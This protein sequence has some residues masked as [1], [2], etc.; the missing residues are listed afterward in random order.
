M[1]HL[2][3]SHRSVRGASIRL[4]ARRIAAVVAMS[5]AV[6]AGSVA[7]ANASGAGIDAI[8]EY[9]EL[10]NLHTDKC[11]DVTDASRSWNAVVHQ[12][13]CHNQSHQ[14]WRLEPIGPNY[15]LRNL[16]S[17]LCLASGFPY[18]SGDVVRQL[19]CTI[20]DSSGRGNVWTLVPD[21]GTYKI[22]HYYSGFCLDLNR[23]STADGARIQISYCDT[24]SN[25]QNW[26]FA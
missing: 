19:E 11:A 2:P 6:A 4:W 22:V 3:P 18:I 14:V 20:D 24:S 9:V 13:T 12:W 17:Q 26:Y 23:G 10:V 16:H 21:G 7:T 1:I 15:R 5:A 8:G 25:A